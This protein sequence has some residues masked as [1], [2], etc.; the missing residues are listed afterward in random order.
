MRSTFEI[1]ELIDRRILGVLQPDIAICG[2]MR[3]AL[4]AAELA[5]LQGV[6]CCAHTWN[7]G[8]MAAATLHVLAAQSGG[9]SRLA[10]VLECDTSE[11]P[12]MR[13][14][15]CEPPELQDGCY[16]VPMRPGSVS[17]STSPPSGVMWCERWGEVQ[18]HP[19]DDKRAI[20]A[21]PKRDQS[22]VLSGDNRR[23]ATLERA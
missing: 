5:A 1:K 12:F 13:E 22:A 20:F 9:S 17:R 23:V 8:I 16:V 11:N 18:L 2:G 15:L 6:E 19:A 14:L 21:A 3:T 10:P 4:F 7:G